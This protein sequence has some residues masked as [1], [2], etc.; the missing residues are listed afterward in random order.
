M[1]LKYILLVTVA[2]L[3]G[4][5][6]IQSQTVCGDADGNRTVNIGDV[7]KIFQYLSY[8]DI[9]SPGADCD[10]RL[11]VT[12]GDAQWITD[13]I[14]TAGSIPDCSIQ[15]VYTFQ[16]S[17]NDTIFLPYMVSIPDNVDSVTLPIIT[18]LET[19]TRAIYL[20]TQTFE[21]NGPGL[22]NLSRIDTEHGL[23]CVGQ[24]IASDTAIMMG[25]DPMW[26]SPEPQL[27]G[28]HSLFELVFRR[29]A[30][31]SANIVCE[32]I[33]RS[34]SLKLRPAVSKGGDLYS[35]VIQYYQNPVPTPNVTVSPAPLS[36]ESEGGYWSTATYPVTFTSDLGSVS[37]N[38]A[39]SDSWI[40]IENPSATYT[41]PA[42]INVRADAST[43]APGSYAGQITFSNV[44]PADASFL[45]STLDVALNVIEAK[46]YPPGDFNCD[47]Q[48]SIGDIVVLID[49]LFVNQRPI[50]TCR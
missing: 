11:G 49:C 46:I 45:P 43:L 8:G 9:L 10:N 2:L 27:A 13:Y 33:V 7:V 36:M 12:I 48:V 44:S 20:P 31:G 6:A 37:F 32:G 16:P 23:M 30:P 25:C 5:P 21:T 28:R 3:C 50:P 38:V 19:G 29:V 17:L 42:T 1:R 39:A 15:D 41:T 35:P 24:K 22:F 40:A 26:D 47:G 4:S 34:D 18:S 14:F